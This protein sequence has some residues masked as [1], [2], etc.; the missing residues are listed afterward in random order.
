[1]KSGTQVGVGSPWTQSH[2]TAMALFGPQA[3]GVGVIVG[4]DVTVTVGVAVTVTVGVGVSESVGLGV[5]VMVG[6][7]VRVGVG[8]TVAAVLVGALHAST[9]VQS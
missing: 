6:V 4:A 5:G 1:M 8:V 2:Q 3:T 9:S 7:A